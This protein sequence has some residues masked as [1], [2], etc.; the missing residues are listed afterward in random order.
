MGI[1]QLHKPTEQLT[2]L[3]ELFTLYKFRSLPIALVVS[4]QSF[5]V[6]LPFAFLFPDSILSPHIDLH[7]SALLFLF[8]FFSFPNFYKVRTLPAIPLPVPNLSV[9]SLWSRNARVLQESGNERETTRLQTIPTWWVKF[10]FVV[11]LFFDQAHL[12]FSFL[13]LYFLR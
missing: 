12:S 7:S 4:K 8:S 9:Q 2:P 13:N 1:A 11:L 5:E 3:A 10:G 6:R